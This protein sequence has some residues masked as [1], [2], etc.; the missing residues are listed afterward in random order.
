MTRDGARRR[1]EGRRGAGAA[2][3]AAGL[4]LFAIGYAL[5]NRFQLTHDVVY[6]LAA[7]DPENA[8]SAFAVLAAQGAGLLAAL[9]W[10]PRRWAALLLALAATSILVNMGYSGLV[11]ELLGAGSLAWLVAEA[12]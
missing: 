3:L 2:W 4:L 11:G 12:R 1:A 7:G 6:R 9:A 10:L 8:A 5:A